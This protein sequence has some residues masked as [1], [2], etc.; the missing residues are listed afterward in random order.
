MS[1]LNLHL[2]GSPAEDLHTSQARSHRAHRAK[3]TSVTWRFR[4]RNV[5]SMLDTEGS[6]GIARQGTDAWKVEDRK[7][8]LVVRELGRYGV[9][10]AALQETKWFGRAVYRVGES[11]VLAADRPVPALGESCQRGEGVAIVLFVLAIHAWRAAG[12]QWKVWSSRLM[13][14]CLQTGRRKKDHIHVLSC[15]APTRAAS[16]D[17]KDEFFAD[18]EQVLASIPS[19]EPY[20]LLG[21]L[22]AR[23][24]S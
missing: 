1:S 10:V 22:H 9:K 18:L 13:S 23:E 14:A 2:T 21:D 11:V 17:I 20:I 5:R 19:D 6:V 7:V 8:D 3:K 4:T 16:R 15:Y 24:G 12:E